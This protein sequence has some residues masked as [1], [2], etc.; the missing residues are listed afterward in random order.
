MFSLIPSKYSFQFNAIKL[1]KYNLRL[2]RVIY[3]LYSTIMLS[4]DILQ[5]TLGLRKT[6]F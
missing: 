5:V 6:V 3:F 2:F 1:S 4:R